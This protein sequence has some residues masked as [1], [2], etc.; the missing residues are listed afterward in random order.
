MI[1]FYFCITILLYL[2]LKDDLKKNFNAIHAV[3]NGELKNVGIEK[4]CVVC[5][6]DKCKCK[7]GANNG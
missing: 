5:F 3:N 7:Y 2:D 6:N 1:G 4:D